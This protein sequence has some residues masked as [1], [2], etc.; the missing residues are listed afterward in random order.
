MTQRERNAAVSACQ[1]SRCTLML[2]RPHIRRDIQRRKELRCNVDDLKG[3]VR[4]PLTFARWA[5]SPW[6]SCA[7]LRAR[8]NRRAKKRQ[9]DKNTQETCSLK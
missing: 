6:K 7:L 9:P 2:K 8:G 5:I 3:T 4:W 1:S